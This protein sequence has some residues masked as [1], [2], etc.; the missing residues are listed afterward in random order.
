[1]A[2]TMKLIGLGTVAGSVLSSDG[3]LKMSGLDVILYPQGRFSDRLISRSDTQGVYELPGVPVGHYKVTVKD[4]ESGLTG[5]AEGD[6]K[7]DNER[8]TTDVLLEPSGQISGI[9]YAAGVQLNDK[10][11][12]LGASQPA[13]HAKVLLKG[14]KSNQILQTDEQGVFQSTAFLPLGEYKITVTSQEGDDGVTSKTRLQFNGERK[15]IALA[16]SGYGVLKGV[17]LDSAGKKPVR[18]ARVRLR[19]LSPFGR[20]ELA[21]FTEKDGKFQFDKVPLGQI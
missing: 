7:E 1:M 10:G 6:V 18:A 14:A 19:S 9:V 21:R 8:R 3:K 17:V 20:G 13:P 16:M 12:P 11:E 5:E 2:V 15:D 4:Y